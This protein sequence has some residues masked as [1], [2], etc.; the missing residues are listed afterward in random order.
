MEFTP[1]KAVISA[2][3][4]TLTAA[5]TAWAAVELALS[6][7][8]FDAGEIG[9]TASAVAAAIGTIYAVWR[10]PNR[11]LPTGGDYERKMGRP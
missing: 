4:V 8:G 11:A 9:A 1:H 3:G 7:G 10:V 6:D 2:I 5:G